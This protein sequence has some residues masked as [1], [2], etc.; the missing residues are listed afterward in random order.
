MPTIDPQDFAEPMQIPAILE[1]R[2]IQKKASLATMTKLADSTTNADQS[3][4]EP[5]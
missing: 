1:F 5:H 4:P 2:P 3:G